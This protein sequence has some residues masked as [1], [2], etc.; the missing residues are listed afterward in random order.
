MA[1]LVTRAKHHA[2]TGEILFNRWA[3]FLPITTQFELRL[4]LCDCRQLLAFVQDDHVALY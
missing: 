2:Q 4:R 3:T 1:G